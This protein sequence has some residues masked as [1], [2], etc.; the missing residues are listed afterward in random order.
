MQSAEE[1]INQCTKLYLL[2]QTQLAKTCFIEVLKNHNEHPLAHY[3]LA[4]IYKKLGHTEDAIRHF[5]KAIQFDPKLIQAYNNLSLCFKEIG[6][7]DQAISIYK[8]AI[9]IA[10]ENSL[11]HQ[12][13]GNVYH[14]LSRL[15]EAIQ[16]YL[17]ALKFDSHD[18]GLY[19]NLASSYLLLNKYD[20]AKENLKIALRLDPLSARFNMLFGHAYFM[21]GQF[22][23]AIYY[24]EQVIKINPDYDLAYSCLFM[25]KRRICEW[26]GLEKIDTYLDKTHNQDPWGS[27]VRTENQEFNMVTAINWGKKI[28]NSVKIP[29]FT[30]AKIKQSH[31]IRLG[32]ISDNFS[33]HPVG[34]MTVSLLNNYDRKQF[35]I[36]IYSYGKNDMSVCREDIEK[37]AD[38]FINLNGLS[39]QEAAQ[40]INDDGVNILIDLCGFTDGNR[41]EICAMK[42]APIQISWAEVL[43]TTGSSFFDYLIT[44]ETLVPFSEKKYYSEKLIY[45]P[46]FSY[47]RQ[48][49]PNIS[50]KKFTRK[51]FDLPENSF[52]FGIFHQMFKIEPT[53][54]SAWMNILK[55]V[56]NSVLWLWEQNKEGATNLRKYATTAGVDPKRLIFA[57][58]MSAD[59]FFAR[60]S[61][62]DVA[63]D[64]FI[65]GGG[66][67]TYQALLA[68]VPVVSLYGNHM[69][70]HLGASI[71]EKAELTKL[72]AYTPKE[73]ENIVIELAQNPDKLNKIKL[74]LVPQKLKQTLLYTIPIIKSLEK[75]YVKIWDIY[76]NNDL[77]KEIII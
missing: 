37:K 48:S 8:K 77:P 50:K 70:S 73:Y 5:K 25:A 15:N 24:Y 58:T 53:V 16:C 14:E 35:E 60:L 47:L 3:N 64:T 76:K 1:R 71:L 61:L 28:K 6:E 66:I 21:N 20:D 44:D 31:K 26:E 67:T 32:Y 65:Y 30:F 72:I 9:K 57:P 54:W 62:A 18:P 74:Q 42:P 33:D 11:L 29:D 34:H 52:V 40:K 41:L 27:I 55:K 63:L 75:A 59:D 56:P 22:S 43:G 45:L 69:A 2:G 7:F 10:P 13:L 38:Q 68:G 51:E 12:N 46:G 49:N 19:A 4:T 39:N 36:C 17:D 23:K